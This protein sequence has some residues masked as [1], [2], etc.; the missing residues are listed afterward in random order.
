MKS[1]LI[2]VAV[3][4]AG[5][6]KSEEIPVYSAVPDFSLTERSNRA[7]T[8]KDLDGKIWIA[9][10]IFTHCGGVCPAMS[11]QMERLQARLPVKSC[12]SRSLWT[13]PA[14]PRKF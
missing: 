8:R 12:L 9:D 10:F 1:L 5:C 2:L 11:S 7:I 13:L 3:V 14:T 4:F 6:S